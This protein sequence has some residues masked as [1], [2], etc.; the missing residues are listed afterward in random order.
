LLLSAAFSLDG[1]WVAAAGQD[2]VVLLMDWASAQPPVRLTGHKGLVAAVA[3]S[4]DGKVLASVGV[5]D[6]M[7]RLWPLDGFDPARPAQP[8]TAHTLAAPSFL[9]DLAFSPDSKR[10]AGISRDVVK[11]WDGG[12]R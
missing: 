9:C 5:E 3:F 6:R 1:R 2:G 10:L 4:G 11:L 8:P 7:L 12:T